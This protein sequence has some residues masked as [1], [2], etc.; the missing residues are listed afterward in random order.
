M[1][2]VCVLG[3]GSWGTTLAVHFATTGHAV[4]LWGHDAAELAALESDRENRKFLPG[5]KLPDRVKVCPELEAA[6]VAAARTLT[7]QLGGAAD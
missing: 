1:S 7:E 5:I 6:L 3:P 2:T 4:R